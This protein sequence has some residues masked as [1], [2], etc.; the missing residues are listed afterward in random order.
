[1][2]EVEIEL[3]LAHGAS[4]PLQVEN[5]LPSRRFAHVRREQPVDDDA[6][7]RRLVATVLLGAGAL[8]ASGVVTAIDPWPDAWAL[9]PTAASV[10]ESSPPIAARIAAGLLVALAAVV[11]VRG[12]RLTPIAASHFV[13]GAGLVAIAIVT[14]ASTTGQGTS[15]ALPWAMALAC[16]GL[17]GIALRHA[18]D[19]WLEEL[20]T[21]VA[22]LAVMATVALFAA[23]QILRAL[24]HA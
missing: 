11:C 3:D 14:V 6:S 21:S 2:R 15:Q 13:A 22:L 19:A 7:S 8:I 24:F 1:V 20:W 16:A 4:E 10:V 9:V 5:V 17:A 18:V 23:L 12:W